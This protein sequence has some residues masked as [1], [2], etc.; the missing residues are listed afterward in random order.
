MHIRPELA[1]LRSDDAPQRR[2]QARLIAVVEDVEDIPGA[3][4]GQVLTIHAAGTI[5][6]RARAWC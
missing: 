2:A 1:A 3:A 4:L 6:G 5:A